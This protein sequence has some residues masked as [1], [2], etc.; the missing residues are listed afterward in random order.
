MSYSKLVNNQSELTEVSSHIID[1]FTRMNK[2]KNQ[3]KKAFI[4]FINYISNENINLS[5]NNKNNINFLQ[6]VWNNEDKFEL[7]EFIL[8]VEENTN[9]FNIKDIE[10]HTN[11]I[12]IWT[13]YNAFTQ[14][15]LKTSKEINKIYLENKK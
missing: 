11:L 10:P 7:E 8:I 12:K 6:N 14:E 3:S 13:V 5:N 9:N 4:T 15:T 2:A 1:T